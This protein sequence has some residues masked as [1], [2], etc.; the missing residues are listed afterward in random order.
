MLVTSIRAC[1]RRR[2]PR[3]K[4]TRINQYFFN[5]TGDNSGNICNSN[6]NFESKAKGSD[7]IGELLEQLPLRERTRA[8]CEILDILDKYTS[9]EN[10]V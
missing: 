8:M 3:R 6:A 7:A 5:I 4:S 2:A 10:G 1:D 9:P